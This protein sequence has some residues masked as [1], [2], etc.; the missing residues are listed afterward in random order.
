MFFNQNFWHYFHWEVPKVPSH[1]TIPLPSYCLQGRSCNLSTL[2]TES[3]SSIPGASPLIMTSV[4]MPCLISCFTSTSIPV[5]LSKGTP[6]ALSVSEKH[7]K[8]L[9]C[10]K[11]LA[12]FE[13][14]TVLLLKIQV[15]WD[16]RLCLLVSSSWHL[17]GASQLTVSQPRKL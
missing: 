4:K 17:P 16:V 2:P 5:S 8:F 12:G 11:V 6:A 13:V 15:L 1:F 10:F 7:E 3:C 14:F 9:P